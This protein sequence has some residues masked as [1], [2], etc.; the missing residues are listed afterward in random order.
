[1]SE[2]PV[3]TVK[4]VFTRMAQNCEQILCAW[5]EFTDKI[6]ANNYMMFGHKIVTR[7]VDCTDPNSDDYATEHAYSMNR[8]VTGYV[9]CLKILP[10]F[11]SE[12]WVPM[13]S[14]F[15][16]SDIIFYFGVKLMHV[17]GDY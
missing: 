4:C 16:A 7:M 13:H 1:M 17:E 3:V 14:N 15:T 10:Q 12:W 2:I 6:H 9:C 8:T 11:D 5:R